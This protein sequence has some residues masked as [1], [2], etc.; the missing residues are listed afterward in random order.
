MGNQAVFFS[1]KLEMSEDVSAAGAET[2]PAVCIYTVYIYSPHLSSAYFSGFSRFQHYFGT[3][4]NL[5]LCYDKVMFRDFLS[6]CSFISLNG[7]RLSVFL[8][9]CKLG[10]F[11]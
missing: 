9:F 2:T 4:L 6:F 11:C 1:K 8:L 5:I 3:A 7:L 10:T